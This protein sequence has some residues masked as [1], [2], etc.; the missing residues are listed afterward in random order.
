MFEHC[1]VTLV[2]EGQEIHA[3]KAILAARS[4]VFKAMFAHQMSEAVEGKVMIDDIAADV[5]NELLRSEQSVN[6]VLSALSLVL[7][8]LAS[9]TTN[10]S[11]QSCWLLLTDS[12]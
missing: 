3:H 7:S 11:F 9:A 12:K 6:S 8:T 1:D 2:V 5:L 4:P 10:S